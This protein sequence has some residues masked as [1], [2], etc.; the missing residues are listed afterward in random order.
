MNVA[1]GS[2]MSEKFSNNP[3]FLIPIRGSSFCFGRME[4]GLLSGGGG[5]GGVPAQIPI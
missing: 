2:R 5:G 1:S 4:G 3:L